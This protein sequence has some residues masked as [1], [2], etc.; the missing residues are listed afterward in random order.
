MS[1]SVI[2]KGGAATEALQLWEGEEQAT[3]FKVAIARGSQVLRKFPRALFGHMLTMFSPGTWFSKR[4]AI[5]EIDSYADDDGVGGGR[6]RDAGGG[7]S[8]NTGSDDTQKG[9]QRA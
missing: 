5:R 3:F 6:L 9:N 8:S 2:G 7:N 4:M 1:S